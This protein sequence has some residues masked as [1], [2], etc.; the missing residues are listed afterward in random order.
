M[1]CNCKTQQQRCCNCATP[2][3]R[4]PP[5]RG[6]YKKNP[7]R[8]N[9]NDLPTT[10]H[11]FSLFLS[12]LITLFL[13]FA[14]NDLAQH[15]HTIAVHERYTRQTFAILERIANKRLLWLEAALRHLI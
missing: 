15:N 5:E 8:P 3:T 6:L 10:C 11:A 13:P 14:R 7:F 2:T 1:S 4:S 12:T 9:E